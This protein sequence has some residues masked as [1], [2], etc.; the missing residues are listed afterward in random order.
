LVMEVSDERMIIIY[1][2]RKYFEKTTVDI[3]T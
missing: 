3:Y 1:D 2:Q